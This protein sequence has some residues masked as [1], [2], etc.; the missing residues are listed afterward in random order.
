[1]NVDE[2]DNNSNHGDEMIKANLERVE[3]P[4][5]TDLFGSSGNSPSKQKKGGIN[6]IISR[7]QK[8]IKQEGLC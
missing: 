8:N 7:L 2:Q 1:M 4:V 3:E 5:L 6:A